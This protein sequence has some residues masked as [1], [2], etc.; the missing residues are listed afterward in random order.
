MARAVGLND[1][2]SAMILTA[3]S[4]TVLPDEYALAITMA[5]THLE[6]LKLRHLWV[7]LSPS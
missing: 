3:L 2:Y 7:S 6:L 1:G 5:Q 4:A